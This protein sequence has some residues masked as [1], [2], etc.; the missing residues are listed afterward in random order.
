[1]RSVEGCR[2]RLTQR[3]IRGT[4]RRASAGGAPP[5]RTTR[6]TRDF[7]SRM[8]M[9]VNTASPHSARRLYPEERARA[10][11]VARRRSNG[12]IVDSG[13]DVF[14]AAGRAMKAVVREYPMQVRPST[15]PNLNSSRSSVKP[16]CLRSKSCPNGEPDTPDDLPVLFAGASPLRRLLGR[17]RESYGSDANPKGLALIQV[18]KMYRQKLIAI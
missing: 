7:P 14:E 17:P 10:G 6:A 3:L 4:D 9:P 1:V 18:S 13:L 15:R 16:C 8:A 5:H 2:S 11:T 12:A